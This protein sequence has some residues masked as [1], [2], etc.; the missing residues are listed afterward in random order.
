[1]N[2]Q[3]RIEVKQGGKL[4][5]KEISHISEAKR[6]EWNTPPLDDEQK[7]EIFVLIKDQDNNILAHG[8]LIKID[9]VT[10]MDE[11]FTLMGIGGI[12]STIRGKGYGRKLMEAIRDYL[13]VNQLIGVGF[14]GIPAFYE[15]CG[16]LSDKYLLQ[17]FVYIDGNKRITNITDE[18]LV[19]FD[20]EDKLMNK[21]IQ[22]PKNEV[23]LPR[24]PDW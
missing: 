1:M 10:F 8:Q 20:P 7:E 21:V 6:K 16:F 2:M 15:K 24:P 4:S 3:T 18:C 22:N 14:T 5:T 19:Y 23:I 13:A 12:I 17:Q 9:N 11:K